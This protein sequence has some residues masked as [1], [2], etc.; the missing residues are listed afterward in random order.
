VG[1]VASG[2]DAIPT[3]GLARGET[4]TVNGLILPIGPARPS[5]EIGVRLVHRRRSFR[6]ELGL[7]SKGISF[8]RPRR[9]FL[10]ELVLVL[11]C[12]SNE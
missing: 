1:C 10:R 11:P 12:S 4:E 3:I 6:R 8:M 7:E 5:G 9:S 2:W